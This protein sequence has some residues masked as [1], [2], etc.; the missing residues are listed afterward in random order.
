MSIQLADGFRILE[1]DELTGDHLKQLFDA[2]LRNSIP[3]DE[4]M[5]LTDI[6][7]VYASPDR[8]DPAAVVTDAEGRVVAGMLS[9]IYPASRVLLVGYLAARHD[10]R[11]QGLGSALVRQC[12]HRWRSQTSASMVLLEIDDPRCHAAADGYGDPRARVRFYDRF[13]AVVLPFP[14]FQPALYPDSSRVDGMLLISIV[15]PSETTVEA[16]T[17]TEFLNEYFTACEGAAAASDDGLARLIQSVLS[18]S[19][20]GRLPVYPLRDFAAA[21][22]NEGTQA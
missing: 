4:L 11:G 3:A 1:G 19:V 22:S 8:R 16:A 13:G 12:L 21:V 9:E 2:V 14:Y 18:Q 5:S 17:I 10:V 7:K 15:D 6:L 20:D